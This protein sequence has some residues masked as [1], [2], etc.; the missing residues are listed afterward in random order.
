MNRR[1]FAYVSAL[2]GMVLE[3]AQGKSKEIAAE[4]I[5]DAAGMITEMVFLDDCVRIAMY[6]PTLSKTAQKALTAFP[7]FVRN[8][9]LSPLLDASSPER[10]AL[11]AGRVYS[12]AF[13][14]HRKSVSPES[15]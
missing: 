9:A 11:A 5:P 10:Y 8:G 2:A 12:E 13:H 6:D 15:R 1:Q 3:Q 4:N 7:G 14:S